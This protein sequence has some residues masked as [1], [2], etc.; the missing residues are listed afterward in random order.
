MITDDRTFAIEEIMKRE[1][2]REVLNYQN[3][4]KF[5]SDSQWSFLLLIIMANLCHVFNYFE[6]LEKG[7]DWE[8]WIMTIVFQII[9]FMMMISDL[10]VIKTIQ[11][12]LTIKILEL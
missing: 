2:E 3:S 12:V 5:H 11:N 8:F 6:F 1:K 4:L 7:Y 9:F 10:C